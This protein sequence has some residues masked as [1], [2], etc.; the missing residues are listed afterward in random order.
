[1]KGELLKKSKTHKMMDPDHP[2]RNK[3]LEDKLNTERVHSSLKYKI[4][5]EYRHFDVLGHYDV[6]HKI[7]A[8]RARNLLH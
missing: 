5:K 8:E 4:E 1:M 3:P 2:Y 6:N 7:E